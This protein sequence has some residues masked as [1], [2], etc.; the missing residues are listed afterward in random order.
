MRPAGR[1]SS[2]SSIRRCVSATSRRRTISRCSPRR[3]SWPRSIRGPRRPSPGDRELF[4]RDEASLSDA[5]R[6]APRVPAERLELGAEHAR[7]LRL[8]RLGETKAAL[9]T[10]DRALADARR[11]S[12]T[13]LA[14]PAPAPDPA[15]A[16]SATADPPH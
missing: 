7:A 13:P 5:L 12:T 15:A 1:D 11:A 10:L 6:A 4:L 16:P 9:D 3:C 14:A 8:L 2:S